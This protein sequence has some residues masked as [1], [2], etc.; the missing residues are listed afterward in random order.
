MTNFPT[1]F[2]D[3]NYGLTEYD[4]SPVQWRVSIYGI[5]IR[6]QKLLV[7]KS[8]EENYFDIPGGGVELGEALPDALKREG[9]EEAGHELRAIRPVWTE[10]DWFYHNGENAFYRSLQIYW[11]AESVAELE[12]P[13]D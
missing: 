7:I 3:A 12:K 10:S 4:G 5:V 6:D 8:S 9:I 13:T 1:H 2:R 11:L